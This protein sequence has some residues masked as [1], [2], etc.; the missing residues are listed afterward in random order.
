MARTV[1]TV[2]PTV[3]RGEVIEIRTLIQHSMETGYRPGVDGKVLPRD[4]IRRFS[5][6]FNDG[7]ADELV[8]SADLYAAVAANPYLAF[9]MLAGVSGT[10]T[11]LWEGDNGFRH[12]ET[13]P[14]AAS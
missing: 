11:F 12:L 2:P 3:K 1:I 9:H 6:T 13:L 14:F 7:S 10:L 5:C 8:C 4:L